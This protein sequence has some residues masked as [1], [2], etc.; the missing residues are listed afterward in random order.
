MSV[1]LRIE[2]QYKYFM[3]FVA[4]IQLLYIL[5]PKHN[6]LKLNIKNDDFLGDK[7]RNYIKPILEKWCGE[8]LDRNVTIYGIRRYL[9][10]SWMALHLDRV[11]THIISAILQV[12]NFLNSQSVAMNS[13]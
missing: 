13:H 12:S 1:C 4:F 7:I 9:R 3:Q 8:P 2:K 5:E 11:P 6:I 10:G